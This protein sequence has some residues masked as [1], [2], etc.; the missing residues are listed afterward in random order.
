[1]GL[2][3]LSF[4]AGLG[5]GYMNQSRY[6]DRQDQLAQEQARRDKLTDIAA[7]EAQFRIDQNA[8]QAKM[9]RDLD[10]SNASAQINT[11]AA[12]L[13]TG[14]GAK[15]Y[16]MPA[17]Q[18]VASSDA[19]Q[20]R[21]DQAQTTGVEPAPA[22]IKPGVGVGGKLFDDVSGGLKAAATYNDPLEKLK[23]SV[24]VI[25]NYNPARALELQGAIKA[26]E[27]RRADA[28]VE[29]LAAHVMKQPDMKSA[30]GAAMTPI[31]NVFEPSGY[32]LV[33][34]TQMTDG[35]ISATLEKKNEAGEWEFAGKNFNFKTPGDIATALRANL[36]PTYALKQRD[37]QAAAASAVA[38]KA[39]MSVAG[40]AGD[41][42]NL[43]PGEQA[44]QLGMDGSVRVAAENTQDPPSV[45]A[46]KLKLAA[47]KGQHTDKVPQTISM[48]LDDNKAAIPDAMLLYRNMLANNP[49]MPPEHAATISVAL[50]RD[51][52]GPVGAKIIETYDHSTGNFQRHFVGSDIKAPDGRIVSLGAQRT[53]KLSETPYDPK[54]VSDAAAKDAAAKLAAGLG[55]DAAKRYLSL[56]DGFFADKVKAVEAELPKAISD[57]KGDPARLAK[58]SADYANFVRGAQVE[59]RN[60]DLIKRFYKPPAEKKAASQAPAAPAARPTTS[61]AIDADEFPHA[62][63]YAPSED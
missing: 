14:S 34:G 22:T 18:D 9:Q 13:D 6:Q 59:Q 11:D 24:A 16:D 54:F 15:V 30:F 61:P 45:Q 23:R 32:R 39:A 48:G 31:N 58:I 7:Q 10:E 1:M 56:P 28:H 29:A 53:Y 63:R 38:Q 3:G 62:S 33:G 19:R 47:E 21:R 46:E 12:S 8:R 17:G 26:E 41:I 25:S 50:A 44:I 37:A 36:S 60:A 27:D 40:R 20:F 49:N 5:A 35:S 52:R 42:K 2:A 51:P 43:S 55:A 57:A 4:A